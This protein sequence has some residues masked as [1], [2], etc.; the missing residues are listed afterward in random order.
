MCRLFSVIA[1]HCIFLILTACGGEQSPSSTQSTSSAPSASESSSSSDSSVATS[2]DYQSSPAY[3][4]ATSIIARSPQGYG[5]W[6]YETGTVLRGMEEVYL[7]TGDQQV[8]D[9]I[10]NTVDNVVSNNGNI[11]SY[12]EGEYNLDQIK[13]GSTLLFLYEQTGLEKYKL[14]ADQLRTQLN[15]QPTTASGGYWHKNKYPNQMWLDGLYMA[16]P[17]SAHYSK[18]FEDG[19]HFD[20][21]LLQLNLMAEK[22]ADPITGLLYHAWDES[23]AAFWA[24][25]Q[26]QQSPI[27]WGRSL[28]WYMM[29]LVDVLDHIPEA[30]PEHRTQLIDLLQTLSATLALYQDA[31][32]VWWQIVDKPAEPGN[33]QESS[34]TAMYVYAMAKGVRLGYL[35]QSLLPVI[36]QGWQGLNEQFIEEQ[37]SLLTLTDTCEG[38]GVSNTYSFYAGRRALSNDPKGLGPYLM[39]AVEMTYL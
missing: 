32:G 4:M 39:A 5:G 30:Y 31:D 14:A 37:N 25:P 10:Q 27:F 23:G 12:F 9:Y 1:I 29:A 11:A 13:Q 15:N 7:A 3:R 19:E 16:E 22:S 2:D 8:F 34:A 36:E 6:N 24:D 17:F 21:V 20:E 18:L 35:P 28:G 33:W 26:T 38:T